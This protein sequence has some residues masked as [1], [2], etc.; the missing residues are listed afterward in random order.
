MA[1]IQ[2]TVWIIQVQEN[3]GEIYLSHEAHWGVSRKCAGIPQQRDPSNWKL[4]S[5]HIIYF[6]MS[7]L[8]WLQWCMGQLTSHHPL[9]KCFT[10]GVRGREK[11]G[12]PAEKIRPC[13]LYSLSRQ[14]TVYSV[15][16]LHPHKKPEVQL[17]WEDFSFFIFFY[18]SLSSESVSN[19][20][21]WLCLVFDF[22]QLM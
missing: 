5:I 22:W 17:V 4:S 8:C 12:N 3:Q 16:F 15:C 14:T 6:W 20:I 19:T 9:F 21:T 10:G 1:L 2:K 7:M 13:L 18:F 11:H